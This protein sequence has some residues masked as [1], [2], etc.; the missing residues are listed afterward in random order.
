[1]YFEHT[2]LIHISQIHE[3]SISHDQI[4]RHNKLNSCFLFSHWSRVHLWSYCCW[5]GHRIRWG[6]YL[7][8]GVSTEGRPEKEDG[9][10]MEYSR[11]HGVMR[12]FSYIRI[13]GLL[14]AVWILRGILT[15]QFYNEQENNCSF[16]GYWQV[17]TL[18]HQGPEK[19]YQRRCNI[20]YFTCLVEKSGGCY[21]RANE[22]RL[23]IN[24]LENLTI[25]VI[26]TFFQHGQ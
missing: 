6:L 8:A 1:M 10:S 23:Q 7:T 24:I 17:V 15:C 2:A 25:G 22:Y 16:L 26:D 11:V 18:P 20:W 13:Q 5:W 9:V 19:G 4:K 14:G 12:S 21:F 3:L